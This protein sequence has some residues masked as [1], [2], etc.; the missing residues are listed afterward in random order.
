MARSTLS[1]TQTKRW[2]RRAWRGWPPLTCHT[3][4][5]LGVLLIAQ[6]L[7]R[8]D[9]RGPACGQEGGKQRG[10]VADHDY[11]HQR[12]PRHPVLQAR[13]ALADVVYERAGEPEP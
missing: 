12:P 9:L 1:P 11:E 5:I 3:R 7:S 10:S 4:T 2:R 8:V 6:R 13:E